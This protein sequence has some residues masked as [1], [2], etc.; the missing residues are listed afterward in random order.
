MI[1]LNKLYRILSPFLFLNLMAFAVLAQDSVKITGQEFLATN[2]GLMFKFS[3]N[4]EIAT[5]A[6][7]KIYITPIDSA[8]GKDGEI[9]LDPIGPFNGNT[10]SFLVKK[11]KYENKPKI[12]YYILVRDTSPNPLLESPKTVMSVGAFEEAEKNKAEVIRLNTEVT[13]LNTTVAGK[14]ELIKSL[15]TATQATELT[16]GTV[17]FQTDR[18]IVY[19]YTLNSPGYVIAKLTS[20]ENPAIILKT[21]TSELSTTPSIVFDNLTQGSFIVTAKI[22]KIAGTDAVADNPSITSRFST[23]A[24]KAETIIRNIDLVSEGNVLKVSFDK[25]EDGFYEIS[26]AEKLGVGEIGTPNYRG[27]I[28][29]DRFGNLEGEKIAD[30]KNTITLDK[31]TPGK[32]YYVAIKTMNSYGLVKEFPATEK[33]VT[34]EKKLAFD[35]TIP[36]EIA[37]G[38]LGMT[39]NWK[40]TIKPKEASFRLIFGGDKLAE[41]TLKTF[42]DNLKISLQLPIQ[43]LTEVLGAVNAASKEKEKPSIILEMI[44][45]KTGEI[46]SQNLRVTYVLPTKAQ[47]ETAAQKGEISE[48]VKKDVIDVIGKAAN[49]DKIDWG[50]LVTTGLSF[51]LKLL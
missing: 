11:D 13:K 44:D 50:K 40:S 35:P 24:Q 9:S 49:G 29:A 19:S 20:S 15:S 18:K 3:L 25:V 14:D 51:I 27:R 2:E 10:L 6:N 21:E 23:L 47:V 30:S 39:V 16:G 45:A 32:T 8:G 38:P 36:V 4:K 46:V 37:L 12:Q 7:S 17:K 22:R 41:N 34:A 33:V 31:V 48:K 26:Y 43:Q 42:D 5:L 28:K 1:N